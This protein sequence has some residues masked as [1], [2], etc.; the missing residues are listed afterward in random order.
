MPPPS[1]PITPTDDPPLYFVDPHPLPDAPPTPVAEPS[2]PFA[3]TPVVFD[4]G[5]VFDDVFVDVFQFS[6]VSPPAVPAVL[7]TVAPVPAAPHEKKAEPLGVNAKFSLI[8]TAP[9][10]PPRP[11]FPPFA[12]RPPPPPAPITMTRF[13]ADISAGMAHVP[14]PVRRIYFVMCEPK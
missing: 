8:E 3:S 5:A 2:P 14:V 10:P 12:A 9:P 1:V 7:A 6:H 13:C 11:L 4:V